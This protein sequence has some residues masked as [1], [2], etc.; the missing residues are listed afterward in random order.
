MEGL[1]GRLAGAAALLAAAALISVPTAHATFQT[2]LV[3]TAADEVTAFTGSGFLGWARNSPSARNHYNLFLRD[4]AGTTLRLNRPDTQGFGGGIDGT[5]VV[6]HEIGPAFG[7]LVL[8]DT[9]TRAYTDLPITT[10]RKAGMHP[11]L[12][13]QWVLYTT[14]ARYA[15]TTVGVYNRATGETQR[16]G[17][18]AGRGR[19]VYSGQVAGD[20]AAWGKVLPQAQEVYLTNLATRQTVRIVRPPGV[21]FQY[22]PAVTPAGTLF[23]QRSKPCTRRCP[24]LNTPAAVTQIVQQALG[25][26]PRVMVTLRRGEDGG[27]M[28]AAPQRTGTQVVYDVFRR[29]PHG[30]ITYSDVFAFTTAG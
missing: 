24:T 9:A 26:R 21:R 8:Y 17:S 16:L 22:D 25:G 14:G 28:F 4:R 18:T 19:F 27:Y 6:Y 12:S 20:W 2:P 13:G 29:L 3:R 23:F 7:R 30:Y 10:I 15:R 5:T 1:A 11:T